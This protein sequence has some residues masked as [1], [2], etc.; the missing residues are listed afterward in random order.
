MWRLLMSGLMPQLLGHHQVTLPTTTTNSL[1][2]VETVPEVPALCDLSQ[3]PSHGLFFT[4]EM[5]DRAS[6]LKTVNMGG[7]ELVRTDPRS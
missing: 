2:I 4:W 5:G 6:S 1:K 3:E 7:A